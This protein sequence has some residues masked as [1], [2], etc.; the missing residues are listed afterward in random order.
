M[1]LEDPALVP[2]RGADVMPGPDGRIPVIY[3]VDMRD[4]SGRFRVASPCGRFTALAAGAS[5]KSSV[6]LRSDGGVTWVSGAQIMPD[7]QEL[8]R[9]LRYTAE[10]ELHAM[11]YMVGW[12]LRKTGHIGLLGAVDCMGDGGLRRAI[13][14]YFQSS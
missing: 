10:P 13:F 2:D 11:W 1:S 8:P 14:R 9:G 6:L 4:R 12:V 7:P 3:R 5:G